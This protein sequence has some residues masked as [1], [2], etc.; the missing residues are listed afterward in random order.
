M[1]K[2]NPFTYKPVFCFPVASKKITGGISLYLISGRRYFEI[3]LKISSNVLKQ[4][5]N[6]SEE[7]SYTK[8]YIVLLFER[9]N[10]TKMVSAKKM[11][12]SNLLNLY[13]ENLLDNME[14]NLQNEGIYN[15]LIQ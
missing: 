12:A 9:R 14:H 11:A 7:K 8:L 10:G 13:S 1:V 6:C 5:R 3:L 4:S 2:A 15:Y